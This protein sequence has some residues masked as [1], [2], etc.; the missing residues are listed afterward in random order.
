MYSTKTRHRVREGRNYY[1]NTL[2]S[3]CITKIILLISDQWL[4]VV[5]RYNI[6]IHILCSRILHIISLTKSTYIPD[7]PSVQTTYVPSG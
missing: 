1:N 7:V 5:L 3:R 4:F 6:D 2:L